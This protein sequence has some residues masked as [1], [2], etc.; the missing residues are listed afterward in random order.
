MTLVSGKPKKPIKLMLDSGA[1]ILSTNSARK[2]LGCALTGKINLNIL[3]SQNPWPLFSILLPSLWAAHGP[4]QKKK[5]K[6]KN[7]KNGGIG[8]AHV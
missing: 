8:R 4:Q 2:V 7:E 1:Y 6:K 5:K 3:L